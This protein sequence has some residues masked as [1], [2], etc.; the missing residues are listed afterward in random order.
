MSQATPSSWCGLRS[1]V[2]PRSE[3]RAP[4]SWAS[5]ESTRSAAARRRRS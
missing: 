1:A 5:V 2:T 4:W 3:R